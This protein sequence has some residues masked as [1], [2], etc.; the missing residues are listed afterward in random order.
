MGGNL[1]LDRILSDI[2]RHK[3]LS[4]SE[5]REYERI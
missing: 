3:D 5:R 1:M 2:L 4:E